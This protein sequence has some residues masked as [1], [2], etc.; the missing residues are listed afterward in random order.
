MDICNEPN[1]SIMNR[2]YQKTRVYNYRKSY[3]YKNLTIQSMAGC[4]S[5]MSFGDK[6]WW[7]GWRGKR[8]VRSAR[9]G[10][11]ETVGVVSIGLLC[12]D[13]VSPGKAQE[14]GVPPLA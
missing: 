4:E 2:H 5:Q 6:P 14:G 7:G 13:R 10:G 1:M 9:E 3:F 8:E 11:K 12:L